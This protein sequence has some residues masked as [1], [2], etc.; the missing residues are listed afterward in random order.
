MKISTL[1]HCLAW[2]TFSNFVEILDFDCIHHILGTQLIKSENFKSSK[3]FYDFASMLS[4]LIK[5]WHLSKF[6]YIQMD[7]ISVMMQKL[8]KFHAILEKLQIDLK[9]GPINFL[10]TLVLIVLAKI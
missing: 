2:L 1:P 7:L 4:M 3:F 8:V 5:M 6:G 9:S 10:W